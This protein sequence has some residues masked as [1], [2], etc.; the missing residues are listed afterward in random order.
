MLTLF[1]KNITDV[2]S[3]TTNE[4]RTLNIHNNVKKISLIPMNFVLNS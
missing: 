4:L 1:Y 3:M 2:K